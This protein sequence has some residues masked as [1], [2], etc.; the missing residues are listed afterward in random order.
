MT[1][2]GA[3]LDGADLDGA[4]F[5]STNRHSASLEYAHLTDTLFAGADLTDADLGGDCRPI[6]SPFQRWALQSRLGHG[7]PAD[8]VSGLLQ[9]Q[10]G[11]ILTRPGRRSASDLAVQHLQQAVEDASATGAKPVVLVLVGRPQS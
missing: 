3:D 5:D 11:R 2:D 8:G 9:D 7:T 1:F 10:E 4:D 6:P